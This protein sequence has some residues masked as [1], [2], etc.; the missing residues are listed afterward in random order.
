[1]SFFQW[2]DV[3]HV[4]CRTEGNRWSEQDGQQVT[5][6]VNCNC[7][8]QTAKQTYTQPYM[9][10]CTHTS[11]HTCIYAHIQARTYAHIQAHLC[12]HTCSHIQKWKRRMVFPIL[13][14]VLQLVII[15]I[16]A[17]MKLVCMS[18]MNCCSGSAVRMQTLGPFVTLST[19]SS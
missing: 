7:N 3:R 16:T 15:I 11:A 5:I 6:F 9:L 18:A 4:A 1:M 2:R 14:Q 10:I 19:S 8:L 17:E 12:T 13:G